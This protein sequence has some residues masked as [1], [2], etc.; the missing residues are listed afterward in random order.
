[1]LGASKF[2]VVSIGIGPGWGGPGTQL[3]RVIIQQVWQTWK[4]PSA[5]AA[6]VGKSNKIRLNR[7]RKLS[8]GRGRGPK[9]QLPETQTATREADLAG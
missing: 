2:D 8:A 1:M 6:V 9:A 5:V 4:T 3:C 7:I